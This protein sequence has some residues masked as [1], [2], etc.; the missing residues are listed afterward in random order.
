[1]LQRDA[2]ECF[3]YLLDLLHTGTKQYLIDFGTVSSVDDDLVTSLSKSLFTSTIKKTHICTL[4]FAETVSDVLSQSINIYPQFPST[5]S[6]LLEHS[7]KSR[8]SKMCGCVY[9]IQNI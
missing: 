9:R 7:F 3:Y 4:C 6:A 2:F 5:I 1:M 8:L